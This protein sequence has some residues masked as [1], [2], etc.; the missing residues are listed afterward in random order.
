VIQ[1]E[2]VGDTAAI[3]LGIGLRT[4]IAVE[5]GELGVVGALGNEGSRSL[6]DR[7][8]GRTETRKESRKQSSSRDRDRFPCHILWFTFARI[9]RLEQGDWKV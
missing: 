1:G 8:N 9:L 3:V 7:Q 5:P 6:V 4:R 2:S